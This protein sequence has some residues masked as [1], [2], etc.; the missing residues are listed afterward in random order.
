MYKSGAVAKAVAGKDLDG[1]KRIVEVVKYEIFKRKLDVSSEINTEGCQETPKKETTLDDI[2]IASKDKIRTRIIELLDNL[3]NMSSYIAAYKKF[4]A[5]TA[6]SGKSKPGA[7]T[8][9]RKSHPL[10]SI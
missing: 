1:I 5:L 2:V 8:G 10:A 7:D 6:T 9:K 3:G 4:N